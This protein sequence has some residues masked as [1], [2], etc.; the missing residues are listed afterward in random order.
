MI[1]ATVIGP[2]TA[3][4]ACALVTANSKLAVHSAIAMSAAQASERALDATTE[5]LPTPSCTCTMPP[6]KHYF[7]FGWEGSFTRRRKRCQS[8]PQ[9]VGGNP[10]TSH[11]FGQRVETVGSG[12]IR[13]V[14]QRQRTEYPP[15]ARECGVTTPG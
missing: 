10:P 14:N 15:N 7:L 6:R 3:E 12:R 2:P 5:R 8:D 13:A 11:N 4:V 1:S 9:R